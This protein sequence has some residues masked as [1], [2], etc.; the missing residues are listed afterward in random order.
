MQDLLSTIEQLR[1]GATPESSPLTRDQLVELYD[2]LRF[3]TREVR[4]GQFHQVNKLIA[5]ATFLSL[6]DDFGFPDSELFDV[7]TALLLTAL[8]HQPAHDDSTPVSLMQS[9]RA[10]TAE[11]KRYL[12]RVPA[13]CHVLRMAQAPDDDAVRPWDQ[14]ALDETIIAIEEVEGAQAQRYLIEGDRARRVLALAAFVL[15][16]RERGLPTDDAFCASTALI[17]LAIVGT[18]PEYITP[19]DTLRHDPARCYHPG[20]YCLAPPPWQDLPRKEAA[21]WV[22]RRR[23]RIRAIFPSPMTAQFAMPRAADAGRADGYTRDDV[24]RPA[25][26]QPD[27]PCV[28][29][30]CVL[31][32]FAI[33]HAD[34]LS[35]AFQSQL[36]E[37]IALFENDALTDDQRRRVAKMNRA[38]RHRKRM[39]PGNPKAHQARYVC[40]LLEMFHGDG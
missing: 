24:P 2:A 3:F 20:T 36:D 4:A 10:F 25:Y 1:D 13:L 19:V 35:Q 38:F 30:P 31:Y 12:R 5:F 29:V 33:D 40:M 34:Q 28:T 17:A 14:A 9:Y 32:Q 22:A 11:D 21:R 15:E 16:W 7:S 26:R 23:D 27:N 39:L 18:P 8:M 37:A 6:R